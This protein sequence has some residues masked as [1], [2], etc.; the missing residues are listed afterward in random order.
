MP[1]VCAGHSM[2]HGFDGC[3]TKT[4]SK[5]ADGLA[6]VDGL[7]TSSFKVSSAAWAPEEHYKSSMMVQMELPGCL[8]F[9]TVRGWNFV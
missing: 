2:T 9:H 4:V 3:S 6:K 8:Y 5:L 1:R 7:A